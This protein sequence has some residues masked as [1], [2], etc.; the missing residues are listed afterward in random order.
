MLRGNGWEYDPA[1]SRYS[2]AWPGEYKTWWW[3]S[4]VRRWYEVRWTLQ[5]MGPVDDDGQ[6][7][8]VE[9]WVWEYTGYIYEEQI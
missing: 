9:N 1:T 7:T 6:T 8:I 4:A 3:D 2:K 5:K